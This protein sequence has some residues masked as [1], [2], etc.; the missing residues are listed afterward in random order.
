MTGEEES[1]ITVSP[2]SAVVTLG[3]TE[4]FSVTPAGTAVTWSVDDILGGNEGT[5]DADG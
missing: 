4:E 3:D 1:L 2:G 5:I